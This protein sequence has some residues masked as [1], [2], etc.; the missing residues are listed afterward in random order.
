LTGTAV[1]PADP[2]A[3]TCEESGS[4]PDGERAGLEGALDELLGAE[5]DSYSVYV[6]HLTGGA[7]AEVKA[8]RVCR[9]AS[10][11]KVYVMWEAFRQRARGAFSF[12]T[13][14]EVTQYYADFD[15]GTQRVRAGDMVTATQALEWMMS[16]SDTPTAVL[17]QDQLG[18]TNVNGGLRELGV[19]NSGL[20]YP[21]EPT[22]SARDLGT[23]LEAIAISPKVDEASRREMVALLTSE[24][25]DNGLVAGV[26][27]G[28]QVAH[29]TG[30]LAAVQHDAGIVFAPS[31]PYVL[32]V[33]WDRSSATDFTSAISS[34][35][36]SYFNS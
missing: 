25:H 36:Y 17:L 4:A 16:V 11:F 34:L 33:L 19:V 28:V 9:A 14:M 12:D 32:V 5:R 1:S 18:A 7:T 10:L 29:K 8:D 20:F 23:V 27:A 15:L 3:P 31:G 6:K 13:P 22:V 30:S 24:Q 26:P 2:P 35:V 21:G